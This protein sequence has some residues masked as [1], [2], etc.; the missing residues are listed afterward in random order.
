[1]GGERSH[2][3]AIPALCKLNPSNFT[4]SAPFPL[5]CLHGQR[6]ENSALSDCKKSGIIISCKMDEVGGI[7]TT[8]GR[9]GAVG[10]LNVD[11]A[12]VSPL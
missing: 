8:G 2:H 1:M 10:D 7:G 5:S 3:C 9:C 11:I 4:K 6:L 12:D